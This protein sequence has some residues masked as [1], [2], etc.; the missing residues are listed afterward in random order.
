M[1]YAQ[2][3]LI[4]DD[5][6]RDILGSIEHPDAKTEDF[7][8]LIPPISYDKLFEMNFTPKKHKVT[9]YSV[10]LTVVVCNKGGRTILLDEDGRYLETDPQV[11]ISKTVST[12]Q[13]LVVN[14]LC[15]KYDNL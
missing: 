3:Y 8:C 10:G 12:T 7:T 15:S 2:K 11:C 13:Y 14:M 9:R 6:S 1:L 4:L 5:N